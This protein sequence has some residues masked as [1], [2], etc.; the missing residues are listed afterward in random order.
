[1]FN[2]YLYLCILKYTIENVLEILLIHFFKSTLVS[3]NSCEI[4]SIYSTTMST[5][6]LIYSTYTLIYLVINI[7]IFIQRKFLKAPCWV[8]N[9]AVIK[10]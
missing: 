7:F 10:K 6:I 4:L 5:N 1:M 9:P 8:L 2:F 3:F